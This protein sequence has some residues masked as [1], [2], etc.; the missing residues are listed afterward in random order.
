MKRR[1]VAVIGIVFANHSNDFV[2]L[3]RMD[4]PV[5]VLPGGGVDPGE[6]V[7]QAV[8]REIYEETGLEAKI[9]RKSGVYTPINRLARETHVFIC[10][11]V[12]GSLTLGNETKSIRYSCWPS[13]PKNFFIVHKDWLK[14]AFENQNQMVYKS[15]QRVSYWNLFKYFLKHPLQVARYAFSWFGIPLNSRF[16][17]F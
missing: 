1:E 10:E 17:K 4:V 16:T 5:W 9:V 3:E 8:L 6:T 2:I 15:I 14:D 7:E 12:S 11:A 13:L